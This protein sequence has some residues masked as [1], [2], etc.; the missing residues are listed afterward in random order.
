VVALV[1]SRLQLLASLKQRLEK[2]IAD[3]EKE[4]MELKALTNFIDEVLSSESFVPASELAREKMKA[5]VTLE[6]EILEKPLAEH[7]ITARTG[8]KLAKMIVYKDRAIIR[9]LQT[10]HVSTP[11]FRHFLLNRLLFEM[12]SSDEEKA[13]EGVLD[14]DLVIDYEVKSEDDVLKELVIYNYRDER[15][16]DELRG[17]IRWTLAKMYEKEYT[18]S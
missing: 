11:P 3:L 13:R 10:L 2:R 14:P 12:R 16:L 4:L 7:I 9:P 17:A 18:R 15:R 8:E 1:D 5:H 6:K